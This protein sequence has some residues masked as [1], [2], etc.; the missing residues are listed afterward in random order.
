MVI[1]IILVSAVALV[2]AM[3]GII[4]H[5]KALAYQAY[6]CD[7]DAL[8][9]VPLRR[10]SKTSPRQSTR[11]RSAALARRKASHACGH[12]AYS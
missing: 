12:H 9:D 3:L 5:Q 1:T 6:R 2:A 10:V 4:I 7:E 11:L 8:G